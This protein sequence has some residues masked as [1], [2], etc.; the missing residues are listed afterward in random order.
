MLGG[1]PADR[2]AATVAQLKLVEHPTLTL[3]NGGKARLDLLHNGY[4]LG[5]GETAVD[6]SSFVSAWLPA[7][8]RKGRFTTGITGHVDL[9]PDPDIAI[10][11]PHYAPARAQNLF[12]QQAGGLLPIDV[13]AG[14]P[15]FG[16]LLIYRDQRTRR[17]RRARAQLQSCHLRVEISR[18]P[19]AWARSANARLICRLTLS[20]PPNAC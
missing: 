4:L 19:K 8:V 13:Y 7:D 10:R 17:A 18:P 9:R 11:L 5:G 16:D 20:E 1:L 15:A 6:C 2:Q 12:K 3:P 14:E